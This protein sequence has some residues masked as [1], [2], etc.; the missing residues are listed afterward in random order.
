MHPPVKKSQNLDLQL[1]SALAKHLLSPSRQ[2]ESFLLCSR[3]STQ[4]G[5]RCLGTLDKVTKMSMPIQQAM[6]PA[7]AQPTPSTSN[8]F[9][10]QN[11]PKPAPK[12]SRF[13]SS[14]PEYKA[15]L[16]S[17]SVVD[18]L[19]EY[20]HRARG[21]SRAQAPVRGFQ[22][23]PVQQV[24]AQPKPAARSRIFRSRLSES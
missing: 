15:A 1:V 11:P 19:L 14:R 24:K 18:A 7:R 23:A 22:P 8:A 6:A 12:L 3:A 10:P 20:H 16:E 13:D 21:S 5:L 2:F 4:D 17:T 9:I